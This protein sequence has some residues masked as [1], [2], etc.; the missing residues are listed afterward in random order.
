M[1]FNIV[2][3]ILVIAVASEWRASESHSLMVQVKAWSSHPITILKHTLSVKGIF[4]ALAK[5]LH[6]ET[7]GTS[8]PARR[9]LSAMNVF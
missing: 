2:T 8:Q 6:S 5:L 7:S 9:L 3:A 1:C 4:A